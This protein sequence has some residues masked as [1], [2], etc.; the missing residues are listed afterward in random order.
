MD[1][2]EKIVKIE[3][4]RNITA[5]NKID[6]L[7]ELDAIIYTNIGIDSTKSE[8]QEAK[9]KSSSIYNAIRKL[10]PMLGFYFLYSKDR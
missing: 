5:K 4:R 3:N 1:I 7:L 9:R 8:R 6:L 10:D 2:K